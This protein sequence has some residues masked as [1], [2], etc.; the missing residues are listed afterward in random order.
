MSKRLQVLLPDKEMAEIR[1]IARRQ[2][3]SVGEWVR[4]SL[5]A[6]RS[7]ESKSIEAK[8]EAIRE[9]AKLSFPTADIRQMI[10]EIESGYLAGWEKSR[11]EPR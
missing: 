11:S 4:R 1:R 6:A 3:L 5:R 9:A 8:L 7:Q 10:E 2:E